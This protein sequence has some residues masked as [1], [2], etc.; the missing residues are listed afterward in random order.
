[1]NQKKKKKNI[2]SKVEAKAAQRFAR[3]R[4]SS[5]VI[6]TLASQRVFFTRFAKKYS[7]SNLLI[8]TNF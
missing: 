5:I 6:K 8:E 7:Q 2:E 3:K 1:M 4:H